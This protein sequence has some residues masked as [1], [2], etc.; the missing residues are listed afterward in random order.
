M[1]NKDRFRAELT[2]LYYML[3]ETEDNSVHRKIA[4]WAM[5]LIWG[6]NF[7]LLNAGIISPDPWLINLFVMLTVAMIAIVAKMH[8]IQVDELMGYRITDDQL[9]L[10]STDDEDT[11][12]GGN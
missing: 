6:V 2:A 10:E 9:D 7:T 5:L 1:S 4:T 8:Q 11:D 3:V 12:N